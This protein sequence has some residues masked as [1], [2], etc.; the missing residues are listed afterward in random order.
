MEE[1]T[2][3]EDERRVSVLIADDHARFAETLE[4]LLSTESEIDVIGRAA[5]G[6]E[7]ERLALALKPDVVLMDISMPIVD[8]FEATRRIRGQLP[9]TCILFLTGS[10]A[11]SDVEEAQRAG[12]VGYLTKDRIASELVEAIHSAAPPCAP[13]S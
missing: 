12:A 11:A 1:W 3:G 5:N 4:A 13:L 6:E 2:G 10:D 9:E 8:G 7:A